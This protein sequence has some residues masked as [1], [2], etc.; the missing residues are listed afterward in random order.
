M[1]TSDKPI[2]LELDQPPW[3]HVIDD[4]DG[5]NMATVSFRPYQPKQG[6]RN[7]RESEV[8]ISTQRDRFELHMVPE[9][10][11][12]LDAFLADMA[13]QNARALAGW[14]AEQLK[15]PLYAEQFDNDSRDDEDSSTDGDNHA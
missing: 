3:G 13:R 8:F 4:M 1:S 10:L 14:V 2:R 7:Y 5:R 9:Q 11:E 6:R 15:R 12:A